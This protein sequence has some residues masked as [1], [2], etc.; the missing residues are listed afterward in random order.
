MAEL[1]RR[2][3][4]SGDSAAPLTQAESSPAA[5]EAP[6]KWHEYLSVR[7]IIVSL[8]MFGVMHLFLWYVV[9]GFWRDQ[10]HERLRKSVGEAW[11]SLYAVLEHL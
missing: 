4:P 10:N 6:R 1:R 8:S 7:V 5:A 11:A 3:A 2:A 9:Y